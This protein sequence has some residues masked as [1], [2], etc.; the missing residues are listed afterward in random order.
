VFECRDGRPIGL[1]GGDATGG[2]S[3]RCREPPVVQECVEGVPDLIGRCIRRESDSCTEL[4]DPA[5]VERL[6]ASE[7]QQELRH[8]MGK[9]TDDRAEAD[10][11]DHRSRPRHEAI[12]VGAGQDL[13]V[14]GSPN[15]VAINRWAE[16]E[17]S[18]HVETGNSFADAVDQRRAAR[19]RGRAVARRSPRR[20]SE[21]R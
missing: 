7:R 6:I 10:M 19:H 18:V 5:G 2:E 4:L 12:V 17:D 13:D 11:A 1:V 14:V 20:A 8:A 16:R 9:R 15:R 21:A 3:G